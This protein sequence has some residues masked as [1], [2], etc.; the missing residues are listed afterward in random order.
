[1]IHRSFAR[2]AASTATYSFQ[3]R[4]ADGRFGFV[5]LAQAPTRSVDVGKAGSDVPSLVRPAIEDHRTPT[6]GG[7][8]LQQVCRG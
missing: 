8:I 7:P 2:I 3:P 1:M 6:D 5:E 4:R